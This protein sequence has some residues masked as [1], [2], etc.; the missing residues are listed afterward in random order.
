MSNIANFKCNEG[1]AVADVVIN[2][3]P[4]V[5]CPRQMQFVCITGTIELEGE[6]GNLFGL[7]TLPPTPIRLTDGLAFTFNEPS[8]KE[9]KI[10]IK[11]GTVYQIIL[12]E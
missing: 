9:L 8:Y 11:A 5:N 12:N 4:T 3:T 1:T 2:I 10:T 6:A 7:P